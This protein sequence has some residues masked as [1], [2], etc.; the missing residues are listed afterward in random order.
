MSLIENFYTKLGVAS[1]E[2]F[3]ERFMPE[4]YYDQLYHYTSPSGLSSILFNNPKNMVLWA[5]RYDVQNDA[6]EGEIALELYKKVCE[7]VCEEIEAHIRKSVGFDNI[8]PTRTIPM[9]PK[10]NGQYKKTRPECESYICCFSKCSD[11]L[12]MWNYYSKGN[13]YEGYNIG[14]NVD[15]FN[16]SLKTCY[17]DLEVSTSIYPV[18]Y[19]EKEQEDLIRKFIQ[20]ILHEYDSKYNDAIRYV[21]S[22]QLM[23]WKLLFKNKCFEHE[24]EVRAIINVAKTTTTRPSPVNIKYRSNGIYLI[25]Y[26]EMELDKNCLKTLTFGPQLWNEEQCQH[27]IKIVKDMLKVNH[28]SAD[29]EI[30]TIPVRY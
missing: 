26:I 8:S 27:Q 30:S 19:D 13:N 21:V 9:Q 5:S 14:L 18:I 2:E 28:Y 23:M 12:P 25:P 15:S 4:R 17:E 7:E 20:E 3:H 24:K 6:S 1:Q 29:V 16:H 11:S 22:N 10:I